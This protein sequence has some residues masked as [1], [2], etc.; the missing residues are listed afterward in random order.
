MARGKG[1]GGGE[2]AQGAA[3]ALASGPSMPAP[4]RAQ[5][6]AGKQAAYREAATKIQVKAL[7]RAFAHNSNLL[8]GPPGRALERD[9]TI[10]NPPPA[11]RGS[12]GI[13]RDKDGLPKQEQNPDLQP[14][15]ARGSP[16]DPGVYDEMLRTDGTVAGLSGFIKRSVSSAPAD[17]WIPPNPTMAEGRAAELMARFYGIDGQ[18]AWLRG[19]LPRH[20]RQALRSMDYGFQAFEVAWE[21]WAWKGQVVL[22]PSG[23][24]QRA[25]RSIRGWVWDG[26][27]LAGAVQE[28][29]APST[30]AKLY[31]LDGASLGF[32]NKK[33][34][35]IP[36][37]QLLLY[38]YDPSGEVDGNPEGVSIYR[39]G[40]IWWRTKRDLIVRYNM[41]MDRMIGGVPWLQQLIDKDG[42]PLGSEEDLDAFA[43]TY[44]QFAEMLLGWLSAPPGWELKQKFPAGEVPGPEQLLAYCDSQLLMVYAAGLLG[45]QTTGTAGEI[46][47]QML[48]NSIDSIAGWGCEILNGQPGIATT[49]LG[50]QL[51]N[52]NIPRHEGFRYPRIFFKGVEYKNTKSYV[53][54]VTKVLQ[55]FAITYTPET[56][57]YIRQLLDMPGLSVS[58]LEARKAFEA[59][60]LS[61][62][63]GGE[64]SQGGTQAPV[65]PPQ[66]QP[67]DDPDG[68]DDAP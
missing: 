58:Q 26:D 67:T 49:G 21:P 63:A 11:L 30:L 45:G 6:M 54:A 13:P 28:V 16:D 57:V 65:V 20:V 23:V 39:P 66:E 37:E 60:R 7:R 9:E 29:E 25:S 3:V 64:I 61:Q 36:A 31:G 44:E 68:E 62:G 40:Y 33:R 24:Y 52:F 18:E 14:L 46:S 34:V 43:D 48:Y 27:R 2:G 15:K 32:R 22:A 19:G 38:T 55:Y 59:L 35:V 56:E 5:V 17:I 10:K 41:A 47:Q 42:V 4:V 50:R 8:N 53:D 51:I 12:S 1:K